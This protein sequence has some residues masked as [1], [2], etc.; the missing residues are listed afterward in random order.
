[1]PLHVEI[2]LNHQLLHTIHIG[3]L[4]GGSRPDDINTY[5]A[6]TTLPGDYNIDFFAPGSVEFTHRYGDGADLCV[7]RAVSA[8]D[9]ATTTRDVIDEQVAASQQTGDAVL[10]L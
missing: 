1:M 10:H 5:R 6:V 4:D 3:R 7:A 2:K 8:L 9:M